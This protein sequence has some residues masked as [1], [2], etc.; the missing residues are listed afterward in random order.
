MCRYDV[1]CLHFFYLNHI[2]FYCVQTSLLWSHSRLR[3]SHRLCISI[4]PLASFAGREGR[5][6]GR[7]T[8]GRIEG[9]SEGN[10]EF[11][12]RFIGG[13]EHHHRVSPWNWSG[14]KTAGSGK[15]VWCQARSLMSGTE[16]KEK[17]K[18]TKGKGLL[19]CPGLLWS[20]YP[21]R[22]WRINH[23]YGIKIHFYVERVAP[24]V[25]PQPWNKHRRRGSLCPPRV[26]E[27]EKVSCGSRRESHWL[28]DWIYHTMVIDLWREHGMKLDFGDEDV[29]FLIDWV[30][31]HYKNYPA[32]PNVSLSSA[33]RSKMRWSRC[34]ATCISNKC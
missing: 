13:S 4:G 1:I 25:S 9:W 23:G 19:L 34:R 15:P 14:K 31:P 33:G 18:W 10:T 30:Q 6:G 20:K 2:V 27:P 32:D 5:D 7:G 11:L 24:C 26:E 29:L 8:G 21:C 16:K 17:K 28:L 22:G 12:K 3:V